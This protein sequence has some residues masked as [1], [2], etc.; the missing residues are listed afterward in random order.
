VELT[1]IYS[2]SQFADDLL[3]PY[4][5]PYTF[6]EPHYGNVRDNTYE[7][8]S[9]EHPMD[10]VYGGEHL[11][12]AVYSAIRNSPYWDTSL[13]IITYDEHGGL[14][15]KVKP[16]AATPPG[17][18]PPPGY[19]VNGFTFDLY[20]VRVP[21]IVVSPLIP[22]GTVEHTLYDHTSVL[23]TLEDLFGLK[24]LTDR[25]AAAKSVLKLLSLKT[26]RTDCPTSLNLP[27]PSLIAAKLPV[28]P[29]E[30]A[31]RDALPVPESGNL[32]N[33]LYT[34]KKAE[35]ELSGRT[36]PEIAAVHARFETIKTRGDAEAYA[37]SVLEKVRVVKEQRKLAQLR[38]PII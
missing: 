25:D 13:L 33:A 37:Q 26:P 29:E 27:A 6:I 2:L 24:P 23:K 34:L 20:G 9:S 36:P 17:D 16:V 21:G 19:N 11:L 28:T 8:G 3:G 38:F 35:V 15:D 1:D 7:G 10:N 4:P 22:A 18:D 12:A 14:F 30:R 31:R 5:Y 32:V